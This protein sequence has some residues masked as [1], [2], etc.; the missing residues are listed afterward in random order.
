[1][2][3]TRVIISA[4]VLSNLKRHPSNSSA[5]Y[6]TQIICSP[7]IVE[8]PCLVTSIIS[9]I[10]EAGNKYN[11]LSFPTNYHNKYWLLHVLRAILRLL[12]ET[13]GRVQ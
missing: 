12:L 9:I 5:Y 10:V 8:Q 4:K 7:N 6:L 2:V 3:S 13:R 11:N 1:M